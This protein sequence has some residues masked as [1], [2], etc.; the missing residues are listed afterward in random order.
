MSQSSQ[1]THFSMLRTLRAADFLTLLN[2]IA[3]MG[4]VLAFLRFC[5]DGQPSSFWIGAFLLPVAL[6]FDV[7][8]GRVARL[9]NEASALGRELDSLAD[10]IS[11]GVAPAVMGFA[12]GLRGGWDLLCLLVF[13]ACGISRLARYNVTAETL[14]DARGKVK[15]FEGFPIPSSLLIALALAILVAIGHPP[16]MALG[17]VSLGPADLHWLALV[18]VFHGAAMISKTLRIP[19]P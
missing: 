4:A 3:G 17:V 15:Y 8:D 7:L 14:S 5:T 11:F 12:V 13:V 6:L 2:G 19:K 18:Y 1:R 16:H 9:R 10:V